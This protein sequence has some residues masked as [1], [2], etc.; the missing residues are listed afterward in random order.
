MSNYHKIR[1]IE[2]LETI[3]S[4]VTIHSSQNTV[5]RVQTLRPLKSEH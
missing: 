3:L 1:F 2:K 4:D 5:K